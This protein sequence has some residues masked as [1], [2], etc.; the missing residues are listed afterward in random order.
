M[1]QAEPVQHERNGRERA[2]H[3][4]ALAQGGLDLGERD[5]RPAVDQ[6]A[7]Q[8]GMGLENG[9]AMAADL[10]RRRAAALAHAAHELDDRGWAHL[11]AHGGAAPG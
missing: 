7:E 6:T 11:E 1:R 9:T 5:V 4:A 8:A 2:N 3:D 10:G